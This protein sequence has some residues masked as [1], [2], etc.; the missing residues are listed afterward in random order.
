MS[1]GA[2]HLLAEVNISASTA[3]ST[4]SGRSSAKSHPSGQSGGTSTMS[5][6][7]APARVAS[8]ATAKAYPLPAS[9]LSGQMTTGRPDSGDKSVS[10]GDLAP[11]SDVITT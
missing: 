6:E 4:P 9:S 11:C 7:A 5:T 1:G 2:T 10:P 3:G 8:S